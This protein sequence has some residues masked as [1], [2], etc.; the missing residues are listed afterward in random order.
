VC[1]KLRKTVVVI[2]H[3]LAIGRM[4]DRL[5]RLRSGEIVE[6]RVNPEPSSAEEISW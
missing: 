3:N 4:A 5:V 1:R 6:D 2:T